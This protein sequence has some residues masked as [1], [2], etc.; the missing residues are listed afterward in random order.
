MTIAAVV[1]AAGASSRMGC[2]KP[3]VPWDGRPLILWEVEQ[4]LGSGVDEIVIVTGC[5]ADEV[6]RALGSGGRYCVFNPRWPQG[7]ATS[8]A[9]GAR[10]LLA[11]GR[12]RPEGVVVQNVDQPTRADI[13]DRLIEEFRLS[14]AEVVQPAYQGHGAHPV[15]LDGILLEAMANAS[16]ATLGLHGVLEGRKPYRVPMDDQ[17]VVALDLNTPTALAEGR[18]LF[19]LP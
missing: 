16:E 4:L 18:R 12:N 5:K 6:R 1:L 15:L 10:A 8:L 11:P 2:P 3:L 19:G 7:R 13:V 14:H 17:P 9:A